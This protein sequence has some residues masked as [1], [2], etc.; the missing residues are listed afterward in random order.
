M[1]LTGPRFLNQRM[2]LKP[3]DRFHVRI[4]RGKE[5]IE[6]GPD[7]TTPNISKEMLKFDGK[8]LT[9]QSAALGRDHWRW[10]SDMDFWYESDITYSGYAHIAKTPF[11]ISIW[12]HWDWDWY[13]YHMDAIDIT[14]N[15]DWATLPAPL[16]AQRERTL[17]DI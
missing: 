15:P 3:G 11:V 6:N 9:V 10:E 14:Y 12:K 8:W 1:I 2:R 16:P 7:W 17:P 5:F 13:W 4:R